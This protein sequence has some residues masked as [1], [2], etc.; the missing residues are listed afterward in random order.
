MGDCQACSAPIIGDEEEPHIGGHVRGRG[1]SMWH[2]GCFKCESKHWV[3]PTLT[4][5]LRFRSIQTGTLSCHLGLPSLSIVLQSG[6][7]S[8]Q[9]QASRIPSTICPP[10]LCAA[11]TTQE[12]RCSAS[13]VRCSRLAYH[14]RRQ[15]YPAPTSGELS[16]IC[17]VFGKAL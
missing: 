4:S 10:R 3:R 11:A 14:C 15:G 1:E 7:V 2:A 5:S 17:A 13:D 6:R 8:I 16:I 9:Y 12:S